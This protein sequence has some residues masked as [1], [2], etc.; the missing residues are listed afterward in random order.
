[1]ETSTVSPFFLLGI[2]LSCVN[3]CVLAGSL[4]NQELGQKEE[5]DKKVEV[6]E[7]LC[8]AA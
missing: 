7:L 4:F 5:R 3:V 1:M 6:A 2:A 8:R